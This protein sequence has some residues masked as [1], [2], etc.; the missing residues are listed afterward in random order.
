MPHGFK[1]ITNNKILILSKMELFFANLF[2]GPWLVIRCQSLWKHSVQ[3]PGTHSGQC[4]RV[5]IKVS[6]IILLF[7]FQFCHCLLHFPIGFSH[8]LFLFQIQSLAFLSVTLKMVFHYCSWHTMLLLSGV[9]HSDLK[10]LYIMQCS[11]P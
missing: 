11:P 5:L 6:F 3:E 10:V 7:L 8:H 2:L 1:V 4:L 9:Q